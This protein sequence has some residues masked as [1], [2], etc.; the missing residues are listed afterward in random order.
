MRDNVSNINIKI[1]LKG[2]SIFNYKRRVK[3]TP[4]ISTFPFFD[5]HNS[6]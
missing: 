4:P 6:Q 3:H 2:V 1:I 5:Q